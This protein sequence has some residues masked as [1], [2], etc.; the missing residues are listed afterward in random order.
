MSHSGSIKL[1]LDAGRM[2]L[3]T[4]DLAFIGPFPEPPT[5]SMIQP[6]PPQLL[7]KEVVS[8]FLNLR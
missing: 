8:R 6:W 4:T 2:A 1:P 3:E 5:Y 7:E